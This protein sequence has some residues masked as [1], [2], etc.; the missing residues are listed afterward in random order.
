ME[1]VRLILM[2]AEEAA[3]GGL[4]AN[5]FGDAGFDT[6]TVAYHFDLLQ[7]AGLLTANLL[8]V[9]GYG[10]VEGSVAQ[11]TWSGHD[12]LD[13]VRNATIWAKTKK[14]VADKLGSAPFEVIR[15]VAVRLAME[16]LASGG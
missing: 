14:L 13:A 4:E 10:A 11:L 7:Q 3:Y 15:S 1:L 12:Y 5:A 8:T 6:R 16:Q 9:E 2:R